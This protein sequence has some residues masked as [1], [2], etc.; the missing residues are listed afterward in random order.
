MFRN[1]LSSLIERVIGSYINDV[2]SEKLSFGLLNGD[3]AL[4]NINLKDD[5]LY[6][7]FDL[8]FV[9]EQ[10]SVGRIMVHIP[11]THLWSQP[12]R[13]YVEDVDLIAY[14]SASDLKKRVS[15]EKTSS[16]QDAPES[17]DNQTNYKLNDGS[18]QSKNCSPA[19]ALEQRAY[20]EQM[21][22][23]WWQA[24]H[25]TGVNDATALAAAVAMDSTSNKSSWWS[26]VASPCYNI[27]RNIQIEI[28]NVR[29]RIVPQKTA[30]TSPT[31]PAFGVFMICLDH[32]TVKAADLQPQVCSTQLV[33]VYLHKYFHH[34][35][36]L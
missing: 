26:Y 28:H 12:W 13:L 5:T 33:T 16:G 22:Y 24:V 34:K 30:S 23:K 25:S 11:Y 21:E 32:L 2:N 18:V 4:S 1:L 10:G 27:L 15:V 7:L 6:R 14:L 36:D 3:L 29:L 8:P 9:L 35:S 31:A 17:S 19:S 20:L